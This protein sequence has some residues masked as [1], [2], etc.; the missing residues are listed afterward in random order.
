AS[1]RD[2]DAHHR[3]EHPR[4]PPRHDRAARELAS[5]RRS[6]SCPRSSLLSRRS[7]HASPSEVGDGL[8]S[9]RTMLDAPMTIPWAAMIPEPGDALKSLHRFARLC[10]ARR[11]PA[12]HESGDEEGDREEGVLATV[13]PEG[14]AIASTQRSSARRRHRR[15]VQRRKRLLLERE[16]G[17]LVEPARAASDEP[18][19]VLM[20]NED[21]PD[22]ERSL[23]ECPLDHSLV[24]LD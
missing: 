10:V 13:A 4:S 8:P 22:D 15:E 12:P 18:D 2:E 6:T 24:H 23:L 7:L 3:D 14:A 21:L 9:K 20:G 19:D 1:G 17:V 11:R 5:S 16:R